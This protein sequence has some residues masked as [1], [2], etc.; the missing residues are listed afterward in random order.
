MIILV[1]AILATMTAC[2]NSE[3]SAAVQ[4]GSGIRKQRKTTQHPIRK[5]RIKLRKK[6]LPNRKVSPARERLL[7]QRV[8]QRKN[9]TR[10]KTNQ[11]E[12]LKPILTACNHNT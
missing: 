11:K 7:L 6:T 10:R 3:S 2:K 9:R 1:I 8:T 12:I 5:Q 4:K